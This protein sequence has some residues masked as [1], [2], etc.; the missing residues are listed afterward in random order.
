[1]K[2]SNVAVIVLTAGKGKRM[3]SKKINKT[4]LDLAGKPMVTYVIEKLKKLNLAQIIMVVGFAKDSVMAY[5]KDSV[6]YAIQRKRL[7]TGHA[8]R[9]G[10]KKLKKGVNLVLVI[11]GDDSAFYPL[12]IFKDLIQTTTSKEISF[13]LLSVIR[14]EPFGLGRIVRDQKGELKRIVEEKNATDKERE[15]KEINAGAY[16]FKREFLKKYLPKIKKNPVS[17]EYYLPDLVDLA[18]K[19]GLRIKTVQLGEAYWHGVN[20]PDQLAEVNQ[21]MKAKIAGK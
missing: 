3:N 2:F 5:F 4:M 16:C 17:G 1:M 19:D 11:Q 6:D 13:T 14:K 12:S 10:L 18:L 15:I 9:V 7:G 8:T 20:T 21:I